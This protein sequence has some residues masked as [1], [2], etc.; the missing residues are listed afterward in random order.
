VH[1]EG[2]PAEHVKMTGS[3]IVVKPGDYRALA[4][5][6]LYLMENPDIAIKLRVNGRE[7]VESNLLIEK[8]GQQMMKIFTHVSKLRERRGMYEDPTA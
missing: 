4:N 7:H 8:I 5:A 6:I 3:G 2:Q 1:A